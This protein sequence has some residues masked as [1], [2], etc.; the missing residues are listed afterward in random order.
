MKAIKIVG[1]G[2]AEVQEVPRPALRDDYVLVKVN[3]VALNPTD[4]KHVHKDIL[5]TPGVTSGCDFAGVV[6]EVGSKVEKQWR[7]GDRIAGFTHG[8]NASQ[9]ED[10]CF[11]E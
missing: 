8:G 2:K 4:W 7:K 3:A 10:G 1:P 5:A 9:P 11:A 6:E